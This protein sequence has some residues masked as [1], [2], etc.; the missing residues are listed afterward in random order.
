MSF[1]IWG[2]SAKESFLC[3]KRTGTGFQTERHFKK[4]SCPVSVHRTDHSLHKT[5]CLLNALPR[6]VTA[7]QFQMPSQ[8]SRQNNCQIEFLLILLLLGQELW[9]L[10]QPWNP[11]FTTPGNVPGRWVTAHGWA[12]A[13]PA[14]LP[15]EAIAF[16]SVHHHLSAISIPH[17][18]SPRFSSKQAGGKLR[19]NCHLQPTSPPNPGDRNDA[20]VQGASQTTAPQARHCASSIL[21]LPANV[22]SPRWQHWQ[23]RA[24]YLNRKRFSILAIVRT[25][26]Q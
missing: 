24:V 12:Q 8:L 18:Y 7:H 11:S 5:E 6:A 16:S 1:V 22:A 21:Q 17:P 19:W 13:Q 26:N 25:S 23:H 9:Y 10:T 20:T 3:R 2:R 15:T 14:A 4:Q